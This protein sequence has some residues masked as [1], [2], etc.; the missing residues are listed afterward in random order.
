MKL[1][2]E[3]FNVHDRSAGFSEHNGAVKK[4]YNQFENLRFASQFDSQGEMS[5]DPADMVA[6]IPEPEESSYEDINETSQNFLAG[7][8]PT[9]DWVVNTAN[10]FHF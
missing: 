9:E 1:F 6:N 7:P 2:E 8:K 4:E 10:K 5:R 3:D